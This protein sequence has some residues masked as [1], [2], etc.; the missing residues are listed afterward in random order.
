MAYFFITGDIHY[1]DSKT[2]VFEYKLLRKYLDVISR[3]DMIATIFVTGESLMRDPKYFNYISSNYSV[4]MGAHTF[5]SLR[6]GYFVMNKFFLSRL[7]YFLFDVK[8][9]CDIFYKVLGY[10]PR[11]WRTHGYK[12]CR[13]LYQV[14]NRNGIKI[15][16]DSKIY[17]INAFVRYNGFVYDVIINVPT[18]DIIWRVYNVSELREYMKIYK[19]IFKKYLYFMIDRNFNI[20]VQLHPI[21]MKLLD[22]FNFLHEILSIVRDYGYF[23]AP[24]SEAVR[25]LNTVIYL[26]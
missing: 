22:N 2:K 17:G 25:V 12:G 20:V 19:Y 24:L 18:D 4:E 13:E 9:T 6:Y 21:C 1:F 3:Y 16:S 7:G 26:L 14:L 5:F 10:K 23:S 11:V 15:I 8:L